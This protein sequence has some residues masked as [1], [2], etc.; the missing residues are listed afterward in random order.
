MHDAGSTT[1]LDTPERGLL[2]LIES[3]NSTPVRRNSTYDE[4]IEVEFDDSS[5]S[6]PIASG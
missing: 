3:T 2:R 6:L 4:F 1:R 5:I